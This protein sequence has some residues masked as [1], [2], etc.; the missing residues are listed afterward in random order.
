MRW[1]IIFA[2]VSV[3]LLLVSCGP[4]AQ[5]C[6]K[7]FIS[8]D[9]GCCLDMD[10]DTV[11]DTEQNETKTEPEKEEEIVV[12]ETEPVEIKTVEIEEETIKEEPEEVGQEITGA[13]VEE[14]TEEEI[15][16]AIRFVHK[17]FTHMGE[18]LFQKI[19]P[20]VQEATA[21]EQMVNIDEIVPI[22]ELSLTVPDDR[23]LQD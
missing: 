19:L 15:E 4:V 5:E 23:T 20:M 22:S 18:G 6:E 10:E 2:L 7:P 1:A 8:K 14:I 16:Q 21:M 3:L 11:C 17:G 9:G 13:A 12:E